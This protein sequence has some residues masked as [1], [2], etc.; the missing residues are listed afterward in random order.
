MD[1]IMMRWFRGCWRCSSVTFSYFKGLHAESSRS[2]SNSPPLKS[3]SPRQSRGTLAAHLLWQLNLQSKAEEKKTHTCFY[4]RLFSSF[5]YF[6]IHILCFGHLCTAAP[7]WTG[8]WAGVCS[9]GRWWDGCRCARRTCEEPWPDPG[10][11]SPS[12]WAGH[13]GGS[14][15]SQ[16][17]AGG[18]AGRPGTRRMGERKI[19]GMRSVFLPKISKNDFLVR[20]SFKNPALRWHKYK[21]SLNVFR[22]SDIKLV[23]FHRYMSMKALNAVKL[24]HLCLS[25]SADLFR[26]WN[27]RSAVFVRGHMAG[28]A[29]CIWMIDTSVEHPQPM[30]SRDPNSK[31]I[32]ICLIC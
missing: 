29:P 24:N 3:T 30:E 6:L 7:A 19:E 9:T 15:A 1:E 16:L 21:Q 11:S 25:V 18:A 20:S 17:P 22:T 31:M 23:L 13:S 14:Y 2:E 8:P 10:P 4:V 5:I 32:L 26:T 27:S 12:R 28:T